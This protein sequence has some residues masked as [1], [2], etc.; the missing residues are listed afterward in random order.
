MDELRKAG[1]IMACITA[2]LVQGCQQVGYG[3]GLGSRADQEIRVDSLKLYLT[4]N[5][6]V[7]IGHRK[8]LKPGLGSSHHLHKTLA[9]SHGRLEICY[10][11]DDE[12]P[13]KAYEIDFKLAEAVDKYDGG[14]FW[15]Y[16]KEDGELE[17]EWSSIS[18]P[19][20][21]STKKIKLD[22]KIKEK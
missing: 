9:P 20:Q 2:S 12:M 6:S 17:L 3:V 11:A 8:L 16:I 4:D 15:L 19:G 1:L 5:T 13:E 10:L 14:I 18:T 7:P 22:L 21:T